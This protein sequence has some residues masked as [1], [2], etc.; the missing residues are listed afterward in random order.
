MQSISD[1]DLNDKKV[2]L[3][4]DLNVPLKDGKVTDATRIERVTET[5]KTLHEAGAKTFILSHLGRPKGQVNPA[6]SLNPLVS[7]LSEHWGLPIG[8]CDDFTTDNGKAQL[9][10]AQPSDVI[11][12]E[13]IRFYPGEEA[14]DQDFAKQLAELGDLYVNDAFSVSHRAH[15]STE[16]IAHFLP[17]ACGLSLKKEVEALEA[18]LEKPQKPVAAVIGGAKISTKLSLISNLVDKMDMIVLGGGMANTFLLAQGY[19]M[20]NSLVE[21]DMLDE[22]KAIM[23]KATKHD[24]EILLPVDGLCAKEFKENA[25]FETAKI[26]AVPAGTMMLDVGDQSITFI[27]DKLSKAKTILWNGPMGAF[28]IKPFDKGTNGVA[29][30][31]AEKTKTGEIISIAGGGDTVAALANA[32]CGDD[33]TYISTAGGAFLEWLEGKTLPGIAAL[34]NSYQNAA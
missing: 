16:G 10:Q 20:A 17:S 27:T 33:F 2:I 26:D 23:E 28:E 14:N 3:R 1:L 8:F 18:A 5:I 9:D 12:L 34:K 13:N 22:A 25:D 4:L 7:T 30:F 15:A 24:C 6:F 21:E 31:V 32:G 11:L 19:D 29:Q